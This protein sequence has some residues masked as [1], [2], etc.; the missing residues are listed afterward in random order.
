MV[1]KKCPGCEKKVEN[2][3]NFCPYCGLMLRAGKRNNDFGMLGNNDNSGNVQNLKLPFGM[4][5]MMNSL[6]KQLERQL[7]NLD[8]DD[9]E[10]MPKNVKIRISRNGLPMGN[11]VQQKPKQK[12]EVPKVSEKEARRRINLPKENADSKMKRL[13]N[14][15]IYEIDA[16]GIKRKEDI[17]LTELA[18]GIEIKAY[19]DDKCYVKF[20]PLKV[21][22]IEFYVRHEKVFVELKG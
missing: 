21:E 14:T 13:G 3:F 22:V 19:S 7:G 17:V 10:G 6:V 5:K 1:G 11:M 9:V 8:F 4:D 18:T 15:I 20:I 16:P 2:K 12:V